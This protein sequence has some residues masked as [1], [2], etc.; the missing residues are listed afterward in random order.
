MFYDGVVFKKHSKLYTR[1]VT[2]IG[3]H[4]ICSITCNEFFRINFYW[5]PMGCYFCD[6]LY[7]FITTIFANTPEWL[8]STSQLQTITPLFCILQKQLC[9]G[10]LQKNCLNKFRKVKRN[11]FFFLMKLQALDIFFIFFQWLEFGD[12]LTA[13]WQ[14]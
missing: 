10:I 14:D 5:T 1:N 8:F 2:D 6:L 4:H 13:L 7:F 9:W 12:F 3:L 11:F